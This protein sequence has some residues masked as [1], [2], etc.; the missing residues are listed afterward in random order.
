VD[1]E[2]GP[3]KK[4]LAGRRVHPAAPAPGIGMEPSAD[5]C[6]FHHYQRQIVIGRN[7]TNGKVIVHFVIA[8][9]PRLGGYA[10]RHFGARKKKAFLYFGCFK[11]G[12]CQSGDGA[13]TEARR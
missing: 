4:G 8:M 6:S 1:A 3:K 10:P 12:V 7:N 2:T 11:G 5:S 13:I 9:N